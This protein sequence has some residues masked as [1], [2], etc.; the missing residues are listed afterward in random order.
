VERATRLILECCGG[1]A[2][3]LSDMQGALP[4]CEPIRVR[5]ARVARLLGVAIPAATIATLFT[6]L[7]FSFERVDEDFL[8]TPPSYRFDLVIEEDFVEEIARIHGFDAIPAVAARHAQTM[9]PYAEAVRPAMAVKQRLVARGWQEAITFSFVSSAWESTLFPAR[10]GRT[11][12]IAVTNPIAA[13]LDVMRTTLAG[14]LLDVLRTNLARKHERVRV[15]EAGRC[16]W[17]ADQGYHQPVRLGGLAYGDVLPEQWGCAARPVDLFDVKGDLEGLVAPR[18][19]TTE[20]AEHALLHPGR[21]ASVLLD[22]SPVGWIGELHPRIVKEFEIPRAPILFELDLL[23]LLTG[24]LPVARAV[25]R[26]PVV[27]RDLAVVVAD[28]L[29]VQEILS[30]LEAASPGHVEAIRLFDVYRGP[31]IE[32]G[33][34]SL[35]ILVLMQDTERTLTDVKIDATM[36]GLLQVLSSRFDATLRQ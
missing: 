5:T 22:G 9:V 15:F 7:G 3:P 33:K 11:A 27:R 16:F 8:V 20:R 35:A 29:P 4:A 10:D 36:A 32:Q 18:N 30:A 19:L 26:L 13:H 31:G 17:R 14:G 23:S 2:G 28:S 25:S 21:A 24:G 34:K 12:P 1:R 6:R